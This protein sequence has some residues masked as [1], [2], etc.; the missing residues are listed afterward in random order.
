LTRQLD[1][2][3]LCRE[4]RPDGVR[5]RRDLRLPGG[6]DQR[7]LDFANKYGLP[8]HCRWSMPEGAD[9]GDASGSSTDTAYADD[10]VR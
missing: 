9:R 3:G 7:D 8:Q 4:L 6:H 2:A 1:A 10:G 5:H